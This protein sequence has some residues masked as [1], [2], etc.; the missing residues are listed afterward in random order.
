MNDV[1]MDKKSRA[2]RITFRHLE[3]FVTVAELGTL[4]SA[5]EHLRISTPSISSAI[6]QLEHEFKMQLFIR[7]HAKGVTLTPEGNAIFEE[8]KLIL[9]RAQGLPALAGDLNERVSGPLSIG[10]LSTLAAVISPEL[11][12][13]FIKLYPDVLLNFHEAAQDELMKKLFRAEISYALTY[14]MSIPGDM[15][16]VKLA[17]LPTQVLLPAKHPLAKKTQLDLKELADIDFVLLDLP[18]SYEYFMGVFNANGVKPKVGYRSQNIDFVRTI[19]AN[20]F[21]YSLIN[22]RPKNMQALDGKKLA[23]VPLIDKQ[24]SL[25]LGLVTVHKKYKTRTQ[26]VF[27]NYCTKQI[28]QKK[29][30]G[31]LI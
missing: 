2:M 13:G 6:A 30:P 21:G 3:Y 5:S 18:L 28:S 14:D 7:H 22:M 23:T 8:A 24:P 31:A 11:S 1:T 4:T 12:A 16:F 26:K 25:N 17:E 27:E 20:G 9:E 29:I 15:R 19:V 10:A